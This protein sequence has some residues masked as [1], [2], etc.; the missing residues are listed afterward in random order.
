M[1]HKSTRVTFAELPLWV[2]RLIRPPMW[3]DYLQLQAPLPTSTSLSLFLSPLCLASCSVEFLHLLRIFA[4]LKFICPTYENLNAHNDGLW[5]GG[6]ARGRWYIVRH[7]ADRKPA[8]VP[9]HFPLPSSTASRL[10]FSPFFLDF[11]SLRQ[12]CANIS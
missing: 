2:S 10:V 6:R 4:R 12:S 9:L 7:H 1:G 11:R 8:R 5:K 3:P